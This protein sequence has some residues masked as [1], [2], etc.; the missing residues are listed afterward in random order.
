MDKTTSRKVNNNP[1]IYKDFNVFKRVIFGRK[2]IQICQN[3]NK[4]SSRIL[5]NDFQKIGTLNIKSRDILRLEIKLKMLKSHIFLDAYNAR[6]N[7]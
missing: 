1:N 7:Y 6:I 5:A 4:Y 2:I 3:F